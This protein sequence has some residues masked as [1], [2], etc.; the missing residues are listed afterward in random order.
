MMIGSD[1]LCHDDELMMQRRENKRFLGK[2]TDLG[3]SP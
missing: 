3:Q 1:L 2:Q